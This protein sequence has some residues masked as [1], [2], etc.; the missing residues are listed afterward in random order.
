MHYQQCKIVLSDVG[1]SEPVPPSDEGG[2][3]A[4]GRE[5][6]KISTNYR[7]IVRI[8]SCF[9]SLT[10]REITAVIPHHGSASPPDWHSLPWCRFAYPHQREPQSWKFLP[11]VLTFAILKELTAGGQGRPHPTE[12]CCKTV[13]QTEICRIIFNCQLTV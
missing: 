13:R 11:S 9:L 7:K 12:V 4:G 2:G 10:L 8:A 3:E 6:L 5:K 1:A